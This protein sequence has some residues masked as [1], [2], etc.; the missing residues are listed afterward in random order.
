MEPAP[1]RGALVLRRQ[2]P[3]FE[4]LG[5]ASTP[6]YGA[7][8]LD[9]AR[10]GAHGAG[11]TMSDDAGAPGVLVLEVERDGQKE[12]LLRFGSA[13][14]RRDRVLFDGAYTVLDVRAISPDGFSG[15]WRSGVHAS[16]THGR[17]CAVRMLG[18]FAERNAP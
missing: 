3:G 11:D 5:G 6:L 7:A 1:V 10:A 2:L 18:P 17:F 16:R 13:A 4:T 15:N 12:I 9:F 14:N 8:D